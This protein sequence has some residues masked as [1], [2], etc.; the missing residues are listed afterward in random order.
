M[1]TDIAFAV[2]ILALLGKRVPPALRILLLALAVI[3]DLGAI[4][5][6]ALFYS[7]GVSVGGLAIAAAGILLILLMQKLGFRSPWVYVLPGL[8][9]LGRRRTRAACIPRSPVSSSASARRSGPGRAGRRCHPSNGSSTPCMA[10]SRSGSCR[11][12]R[13]RTPA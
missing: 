12:S 3:D 5:V 1:A 2:G 4:V 11:C 10:G 9:D 7:S 8:R 6:I 13:W